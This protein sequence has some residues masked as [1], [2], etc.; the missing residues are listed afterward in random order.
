MNECTG[1]PNKVH[2]SVFLVCE[3]TELPVTM[4]LDTGSHKAVRVTTLSVSLMIRIRS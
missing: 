3:V 4:L 2:V 1:V